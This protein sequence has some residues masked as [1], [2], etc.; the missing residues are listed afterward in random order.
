M[1][2]QSD[3]IPRL[4]SY[5]S[6]RSATPS[7]Y[8]FQSKFNQTKVDQRYA[9][10]IVWSFRRDRDFALKTELPQAIEYLQKLEF[11][12]GQPSPFSGWLSNYV[13][14][15]RREAVREVVAHLRATADIDLGTNPIVWIEKYGNK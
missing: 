1:G 5:H 7:S 10:D 6:L 4:C 8:R 2:R 9:T 15:E 14:S 3:G 12:E 11:P 13:E